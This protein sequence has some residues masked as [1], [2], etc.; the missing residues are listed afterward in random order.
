MAN[1]APAQ[2]PHAFH[3]PWPLTAWPDVPTRFLRGSDDRLFPAEFQRWVAQDRLGMRPDEM[4][5]GH[6][7]TP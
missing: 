2:S 7:I 3:Q 1:R 6:L 4:R 5:G